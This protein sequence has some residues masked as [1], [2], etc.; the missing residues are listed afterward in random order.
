MMEETD[1]KTHCQ[2][3]VEY[4]IRRCSQDNGLAA[5]LRRAD[6]PTTEYQSWEHLGA[7]GINLERKHQRIPFVIIAASIAKTKSEQNGNMTLGS[8]IANCYK[9]G[10]QSQPAN[11]RLRR[12]LACNDLFELTGVLRPML[13]LIASRSAGALDYIRLLQQLQRFCFDEQRTRTKTQWAQE[14]YATKPT[15]EAEVTA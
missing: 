9:D 7:F 12:L 1:K 10:N 3:F 8:A 15:L 6:N 2:S 11:A 4:T 13:S 14:F 5:R